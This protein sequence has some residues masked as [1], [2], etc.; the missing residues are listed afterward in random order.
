M[1]KPDRRKDDQ[2]DLSDT[3]KTSEVDTMASPKFQVGERVRL[4][5]TIWYLSR[6]C[7]I[8][9]KVVGIYCPRSSL[10]AVHF[11]GDPVPLPI[12]GEELEADIPMLQS[13][14]AV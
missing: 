10:Y 5:R 11:D 1:V 12:Y 2:S 7:A 14:Q 8:T 6:L 9:G 13:R 3:I 4:R